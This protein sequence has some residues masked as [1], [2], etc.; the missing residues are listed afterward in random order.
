MLKSYLVSSLHWHLCDLMWGTD[1]IA[2]SFFL[3]YKVSRTTI[4]NLRWQVGG[5]ITEVTFRKLV[6]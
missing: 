6:T 2:K 5:E 4:K 3:N 1:Y